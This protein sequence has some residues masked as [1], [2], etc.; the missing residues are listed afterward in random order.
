[1]DWDHLRVEEMSDARLVEIATGVR[2]GSLTDEDVSGWTPPLG[3]QIIDWMDDLRESRT[4]Y[5]PLRGDEIERSASRSSW[6]TASPKVIHLALSNRADWDDWTMIKVYSPSTP[7]EGNEM[8]PQTLE[9][10][11]QWLLSGD[12]D[13]EQVEKMLKSLPE[14]VLKELQMRLWLTE[15]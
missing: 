12:R 1:M 2:L 4:H 10:Y 5:G 9:E 7:Q 15:G 3:L 14:R 11:D 6:I 13:R 8:I